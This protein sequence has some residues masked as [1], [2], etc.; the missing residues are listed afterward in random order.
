MLEKILMH[1]IRIWTNCTTPE[2]EGCMKSVHVRRGPGNKI[3]KLV[4]YY[5][6]DDKVPEYRVV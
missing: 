1:A 5:P 2:K 4:I 6:S 3:R